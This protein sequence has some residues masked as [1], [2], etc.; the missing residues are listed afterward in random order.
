MNISI[1]NLSNDIEKALFVALAAHKGQQDLDGNPAILHPITVALAGRTDK[2]KIVGLLHDV[3]EDTDY[4]FDDLRHIGFDKEIIEAL[5]LLTH[6]EE[7]SYQDYVQ[8]I[9]DSGNSL[10][11]A[12]KL[13]DLH[14]NL[15]RGRAGGH[16]RI[17]E[18]HEKALEQLMKG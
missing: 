12:V 6:S 7:M 8:R 18:K 11:L 17:V 14:H 16:T 9:K 4:T 1:D 13:N 5:Q 2:E 15:Q 10:A 3:V